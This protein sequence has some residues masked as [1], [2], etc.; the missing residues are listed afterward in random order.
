MHFQKIDGIRIY[1]SLKFYIV[2]A[3]ALHNGCADFH[4]LEVTRLLARLY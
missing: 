4:S 3:T 2:Y 1:G